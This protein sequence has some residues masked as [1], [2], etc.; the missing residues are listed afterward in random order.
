M[1]SGSSS[2]CQRQPPVTHRRAGYPRSRR[3]SRLH[4][5]ARRHSRIWRR[6]KGHAEAAWTGGRSLGGGPPYTHHL[7]LR[8]TAHRGH[9]PSVPLRPHAR[10]AMSRRWLPRRLPPLPRCIGIWSVGLHYAHAHHMF[11]K[12]PLI[13][14]KKDHVL[15]MG[16][17]VYLLWC[18]RFLIYCLANLAGLTKCD[19][20]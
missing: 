1:D 15:I 3:R 18:T 5:M 7:R 4:G 20:D 12:M 17:L 13:W 19:F 2:G 11:V 14:T 16:F 9:S 6:V 8:W 10:V